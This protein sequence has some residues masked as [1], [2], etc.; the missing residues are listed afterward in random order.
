[1][2]QPD[3]RPVLDGS[4][5]NHAGEKQP[6]LVFLNFP[7]HVAEMPAAT[8]WPIRASIP[9]RC[10]PISGIVDQLDHALRSAGA[11]QV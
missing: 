8:P 6:R 1:M 10:R 2:V 11:G 7:T 3:P 4:V 5:K 9:E